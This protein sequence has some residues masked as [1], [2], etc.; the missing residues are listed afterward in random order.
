MCIFVNGLDDH[1]KF[2]VKT[3]NPKTL[4]KAYKVAINFETCSKTYKK[5]HLKTW[6]ECL[7]QKLIPPIPTPIGENGKG[8]ARFGN[9]GHE[10]VQH[11]RAHLGLIRKNKKTI[12][13]KVCVYHA[14]NIGMNL[15][16]A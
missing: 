9:A 16:N 10:W 15:S 7:R 8:Y 4:S 5:N 12:N 3:Y 14:M 2:M 13:V 6:I 1:I 11:Q